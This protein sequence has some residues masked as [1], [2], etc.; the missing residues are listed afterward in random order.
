MQ[1]FFPRAGPGRGPRGGKE[2]GNRVVQRPSRN[3]MGLLLREFPKRNLSLKRS[4][5]RFLG[6]GEGRGEC[7]P[8]FCNRSRDETSDQLGINQCSTFWSLSL[9]PSSLE[10]VLGGV[11]KRPVA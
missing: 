9:H 4:R 10:W 8:R 1:P 7:K 5:G 2:T 3:W 6:A 11:G